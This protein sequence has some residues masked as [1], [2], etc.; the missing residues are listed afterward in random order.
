MGQTIRVST[1]GNN[2]LTDTNYDHYSLYADQDNVLIKE[3]ARGTL[4]VAGTSQ[5]TV[6]HNFGY[7][8]HHMGYGSSGSKWYWLNGP[9]IYNIAEIAATTANLIFKNN[10]LSSMTFRYY[11]F[12]D[13]TE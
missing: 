5:G 6:A 1:P 12:Y 2:A 11:I 10:T 13:N 3:Y 4:S 8:P 9:G 7:I